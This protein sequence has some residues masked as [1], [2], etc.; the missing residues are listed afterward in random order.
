MQQRD[1]TKT[2]Q[3]TA[4]TCRA[5]AHGDRDY[6]LGDDKDSLDGFGHLCRQPLSWHPAPGRWSLVIAND[7]P[8]FLDP[9]RN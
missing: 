1:I 5:Y 7:F 8:F 6:Y 4:G 9:P 3:R 2:C